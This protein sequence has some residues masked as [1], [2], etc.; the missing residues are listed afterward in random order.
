MIRGK[1]EFDM[2]GRPMR[3]WIVVASEDYESDDT[4]KD[5]V[6]QGVDFALTLPPK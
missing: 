6:Q 3:E 2:T 1:Q 5:W 4:L